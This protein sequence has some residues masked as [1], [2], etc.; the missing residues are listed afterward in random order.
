M[1]EDLQEDLRTF[2]SS[3][4]I[5]EVDVDKF[6]HDVKPRAPRTKKKV[7]GPCMY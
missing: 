4:L 3:Y 6:K 5:S 1:R 7:G 2:E